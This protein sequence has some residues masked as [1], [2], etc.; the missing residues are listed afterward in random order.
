M[1]LKGPEK[2]CA[3][4]RTST[5]IR[6]VDMAPGYCI[7]PSGLRRARRH[8]RVWLV[9]W[10]VLRVTMITLATTLRLKDNFG[11]EYDPN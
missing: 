11:G 6:N 8:W 7:G 10:R 3:L 2:H 5:R 4:H 1:A 9:D